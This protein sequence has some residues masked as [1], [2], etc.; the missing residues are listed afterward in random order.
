MKKKIFLAVA[1]TLAVLLLAELALRIFWVNPYSGTGTDHVLKLRHHHPG[2]NQSIGRE[3]IDTDIPI[4][5]LRTNGRGYIEPAVRFERPDFTVVFMGGSTTE[6]LAV[7]EEL[8]FPV[9]VSKMLEEK[10]L[11]VNCLNS[12]RSGGTLHDSI[13]V[14]FNHVIHDEPDVV[15]LMH[16][17]NDIGILKHDR[18]YRSRQGSPVSASHIAK[19]VLQSLS[20]GSSLFGILRQAATVA[21]IAEPDPEQFER[22]REIPAPDPFAARLKVFVEMC[23]AFGITPVLMTQPQVSRLH[24]ELTPAW[25]DPSAQNIFNRAIREVGAETGADVIDLAAMVAGHADDI[26]ELKKI[27]YDGSHVRDY[28]SRVYARMISEQLYELLSAASGEESPAAQ[29]PSGETQ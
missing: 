29:V 17:T 4:V 8:R 19:Y 27:F 23:R 14:L 20:S 25:S 1:S 3:R 11:E 22:T 9:L 6:C 24:N 7:Q 28:G 21:D 2:I 15:I 13:N 10:G 26:E 12:G 16:A 5:R 18:D